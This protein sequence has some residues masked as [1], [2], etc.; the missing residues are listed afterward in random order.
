MKR[1]LVLLFGSLLALLVAF[2]GYWLATEYT[3]GGGV[4]DSRGVR[5]FPE[6]GGSRLPTGRV[7]SGDPSAMDLEGGKGAVIAPRD[8]KGRLEGSERSLVVAVLADIYGSQ[9][10]L[11]R[12]IEENTQAQESRT[13]SQ[14]QEMQSGGI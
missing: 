11:S 14:E 3:T 6:Y 5:H 2:F 12:E 13:V 1:R 10:P 4:R 7:S 8:D 9:R